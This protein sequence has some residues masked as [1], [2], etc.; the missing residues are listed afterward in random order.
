[1]T[2]GHDRRV[3]ED[4][5]ALRAQL[6]DGGLALEVAGVALELHADGAE[7]FFGRLKTLSRIFFEQAADEGV[8]RGIEFA[9]KG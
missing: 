1:M 7:R 2:I 8:V 9:D 4:A 5:L 3:P 6:G